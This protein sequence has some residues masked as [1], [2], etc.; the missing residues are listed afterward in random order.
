MRGADRILNDIELVQKFLIVT[1]PVR[2][3]GRILDGSYD[4]FDNWEL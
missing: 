1:V 4:L 2:G 3:A